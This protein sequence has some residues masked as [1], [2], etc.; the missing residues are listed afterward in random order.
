MKSLLIL[1]FIFLPKFSIANEKEIIFNLEQAQ[2]IA[3]KAA[4]C[5]LKNKWKLSIAIVNSEGNL[6]YFQRGDDSY[7]GSIESAIDKA[8]S[9][10]A[11]QRPTKSF[12]DSIKDGRTGLLTV[13]NVVA[14]EGGIPIQL[15]GKHVGAIGISGAKAIEDEICAKA[16]LDN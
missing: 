13:K 6:L 15:S 5:G 3:A 8:K 14:I 16:A 2:K 12:V 9:A 1:V 10:N 7:T 4:T 11:F